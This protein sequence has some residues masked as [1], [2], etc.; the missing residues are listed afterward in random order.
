[1]NNSL[2]SNRRIAKNT[3]MLYIRMIIMLL[4]SLYTSRIVLDYLGVED[5]GIYNLIGGIVVMF[6]FL[7]NAMTNSTQ[8]FLN[9]SILNKDENHIKA[10]FSASI[11]A[12]IIISGIF[13]F[14]AES[15]GLWFV[16]FHMNIPAERFNT[17]IWVYHL[18]IFATVANILRVPYNAVFIANENMSIFAYLSI[19]ESILR[20]LI[21][22]I[23]ILGDDRLFIYS[24]LQMSVSVLLFW[25]YKSIAKSRYSL[26]KYN[27]V[28]DKSLLSNLLGYSGWML[29]GGASMMLSKQGANVVINLFFG[30]VVNA[31]VGVANQI[32][33]AINGFITSFQTAF[34]PQ[35]VKLY[36]AN[37]QQKL[38]KLIFLS[39][40]IS[41]CL[42]ISLSFPII[43]LADNILNVWLVKVP[44]YAISFT[45]LILV[46]S[47][48]DTLSA[49]LWTAIGATGKIKNYQIFVSL[50]L[51]AQIP[52]IWIALYMGM[53]PVIA[54][55]V[56]TVFCLSAYI[57][58][59]FYIL[60]R[61]NLKSRFYAKRIILPCSFIVIILGIIFILFNKMV[62]DEIET[63]IAKLIIAIIFP[64][65]LSYFILLESQEKI[66]LLKM[67][68][69]KFINKN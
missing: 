51:I 25:V 6:S 53:S 52:I 47:L 59:V 7:N 48:F 43:L 13:I 64:I 15:I 69:S 54:F 8:R 2:S 3:F 29:F 32:K 49:P 24:I 62:F 16:Y 22:Y 44:D 46:S 61:I 21:V 65:S 50:I 56:D 31:A 66:Q 12:H 57:F 14:L 45:R 4:I 27:N 39:T 55:I 60:P 37:E 42:Y 20:L 68:K 23:L 10:V 38:D 26:C 17:T 35:I 40:K 28:I 19:I 33:N 67:A 5:F 18:T 1:M 11:Q 58:R 36:A 41:F 63:L 34:S 30:V 9:Y